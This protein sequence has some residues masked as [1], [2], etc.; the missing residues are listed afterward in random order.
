MIN[1]S[2]PSSPKKTSKFSQL[3]ILGKCSFY[4]LG[5][6]LFTYLF[7][8]IAPKYHSVELPDNISSY[9][10]T[11]GK[12]KT[13]DKAYVLHFYDFNVHVKTEVVSAIKNNIVDKITVAR[14]ILTN[15]AV[16][17]EII[18]HETQTIKNKRFYTG[19]N[20]YRS[21]SLLFLSMVIFFHT[22]LLYNIRDKKLAHFRTISF[23][24]LIIIYIIIV[25]K[26]LM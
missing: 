22:W 25:I 4:S 23:S 26:N 15:K 20:D 16:Y 21:L 7:P 6:L 5:F 24:L 1:Y 12:G 3:G 18:P 13:K 19:M 11:Y 14:S 2:P 10:I 8:L 17:I 9:T